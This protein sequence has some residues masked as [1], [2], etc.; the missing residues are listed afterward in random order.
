MV[1]YKKRYFV[2]EYDRAAH[3]SR[4]REELDL[5]PLSSRDIDIANAVKDKVGLII[6]Q[7]SSI[8]PLYLGPGAA[9]GLRPGGHHCG[10]QVRG[11]EQRHPNSN[12]TR[13]SELSTRTWKPDWWFW[14]A[15]TART[16]FYHPLYLLLP[17]WRT[18]IIF[19][20]MW[21]I[22]ADQKWG[23]DRQTA[24]YWSHHQTLSRL[25]AQ[26]AEIITREC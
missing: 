18:K 23:C 26:E 9:R 8:S 19:N 3:I 12:I 10:L 16:R 1:R 2:L 25:H 13:I 4:A 11:C 14:G 22:V 7:I 24:V 20:L 5:E 21:V 6:F 15:D 17:R